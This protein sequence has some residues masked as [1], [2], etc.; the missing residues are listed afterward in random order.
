M[1]ADHQWKPISA[2]WKRCAA[3]GLENH[4]RYPH[5]VY[6]LADPGRRLVHG[7]SV[8]SGEETILVAGKQQDRQA[9]SYLWPLCPGP[10]GDLVAALLERVEV[11]T[12]LVAQRPCG[13]CLARP[14]RWCIVLSGHPCVELHAG[15]RTQNP[16]VVPLCICGA[17]KHK[18]SLLCPGCYWGLPDELRRPWE[19]A[20]GKD[21]QIRRAAA[22]RL[23]EWTRNQ[24]R[25]KP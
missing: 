8:R 12:A 23:I 11:L 21:L 15:R 3:C 13:K 10:G 18:G 4:F 2:G 6:Y 22:R 19:E 25:T 24:R 1:S 9:W 5:R 17:P 14:G 20:K 16:V 7:L